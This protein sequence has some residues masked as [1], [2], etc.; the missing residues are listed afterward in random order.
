MAL[1]AGAAT[2]GRG[3][4]YWVGAAVGGRRFM[5]GSFEW[6]A[7]GLRCCCNWVIDVVM[8]DRQLVVLGARNVLL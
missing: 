3:V 5:V 7:V 8:R 6:S 2:S 4:T 1:N